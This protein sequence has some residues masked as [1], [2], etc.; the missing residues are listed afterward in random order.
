GDQEDPAFA[1]SAE[2]LAHEGFAE[3]LPLAGALRTGGVR[4]TPLAVDKRDETGPFDII[5]DVHGCTD[6]I[7]A[8]LARLGYSVTIVGHGDD[9]RAITSAPPGRRAIFVG[10]L[11]DRGPRSADALRIAMAM[12]DAG[13][14]FCVPGNHDVKFLRWLKGARVKVAH[15]LQ[16]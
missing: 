16:A 4:R 12:V 1:A 9:R 15:G 13:Q 2:R 14:A 10:D 8:L 11:V 6:E 5:G 3:V 7:E